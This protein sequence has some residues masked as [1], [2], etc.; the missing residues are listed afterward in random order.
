MESI[1]EDNIRNSQR[2]IRLIRPTMFGYIDVCQS[3][4]TGEKV[5]IAKQMTCTV[6]ITPR[7]KLHRKDKN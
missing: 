3:A 5:G 4:D 7:R 2:V 1:S 6:G